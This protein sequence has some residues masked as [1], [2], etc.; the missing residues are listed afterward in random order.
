[1]WR[2]VDLAQKVL[3]GGI[4]V[5]RKVTD[6][7]TDNNAQLMIPEREHLKYKTQ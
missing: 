1:M 2:T 7:I 5:C 3:Y 4:R 6:M